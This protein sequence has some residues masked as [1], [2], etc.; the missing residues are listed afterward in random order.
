[1]VVHQSVQ[2]VDVVGVAHLVT[3]VLSAEVFFSNRFLKR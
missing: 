1:M 3:E 2:R